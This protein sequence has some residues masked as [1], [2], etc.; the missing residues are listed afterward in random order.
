ME[1]KYMQLNMSIKVFYMLFYELDIS[2]KITDFP[3]VL[4]TCFLQTQGCK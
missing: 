2:S 1:K 4:L 3:N